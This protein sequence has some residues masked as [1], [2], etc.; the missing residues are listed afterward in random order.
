M[1]ES[2]VKDLAFLYLSRPYLD[3][4]VAAFVRD[5]KDFGPGESVY[6]ESVTVY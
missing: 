5:F 6:P 4:E 2:F 1:A 3:I